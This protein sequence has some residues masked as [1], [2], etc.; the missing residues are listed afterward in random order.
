MINKTRDKGWPWK[1]KLLKTCGATS[2]T[3]KAMA[4][5]RFVEKVV[6]GKCQNLFAVSILTL[7]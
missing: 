2:I 6:N 3:L 7:T 5:R 1:T 4:K